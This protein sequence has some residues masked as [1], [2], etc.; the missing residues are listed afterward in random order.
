MT[1]F[2]VTKSCRS[3]EQSVPE[4]Q[5]FVTDA[6]SITGQRGV[7]LRIGELVRIYKRYAMKE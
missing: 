5:D 1:A 6:V 2:A 4:A 3:M 7:F